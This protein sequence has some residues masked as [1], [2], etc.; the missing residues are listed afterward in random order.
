MRQS[1]QLVHLKQMDCASEVCAVLF[2]A[3]SVEQMV[4]ASL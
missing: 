1:E 4:R 2:C 3:V